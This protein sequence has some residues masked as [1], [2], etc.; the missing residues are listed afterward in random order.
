MSDPTCYSRARCLAQ[1]QGVP[2]KQ[3]E[4][5]VEEDDD[6]ETNRAAHRHLSARLVVSENGSTQ[7]RYEMRNQ[8]SMQNFGEKSTV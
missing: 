7:T 5:C 3:L 1:K 4:R 2:E 8:E 6:A